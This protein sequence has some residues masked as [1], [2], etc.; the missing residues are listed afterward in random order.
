MDSE[1]CHRDDQ[2]AGAPLLQRKFEEAELVYL[3]EEK[4]P[5]TP[6]CGL[7]VLEGN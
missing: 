3:G 7:L 5:G 6:N 4:A 1:E 2:R